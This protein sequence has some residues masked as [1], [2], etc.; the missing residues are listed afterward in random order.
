MV[1]DEENDALEEAKRDLIRED[2]QFAAGAPK[3]SM[4]ASYRGSARS[5]RSGRTGR[6]SRPGMHF[7]EEPSAARGGGAAG[8]PTDVRDAGWSLQD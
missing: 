6:S 8:G 7:P 1:R 4:S 3:G 5:G 2:A